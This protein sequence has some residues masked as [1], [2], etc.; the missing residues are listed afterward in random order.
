MRARATLAKSG[1]SRARPAS[2]SRSTRRGSG[3]RTG[4]GRGTSRTCGRLRR[5]PWGRGCA[6]GR[7]LRVVGKVTLGPGRSGSVSAWKARAL[8]WTR[9]HFSKGFQ[10][11]CLWGVPAFRH[12]GRAP[13]LPFWASDRD[14]AEGQSRLAD[15]VEA[16]HAHQEPLIR[17]PGAGVSRVR[18]ESAETRVGRAEPQSFRKTPRASMPAAGLEPA[19]PSGLRILSPLRLP[20]R[21][22]GAAAGCRGGACAV[23]TR[24][25]QGQGAAL[26]PPGA[27][28]LPAP[29]KGCH[30]PR[31]SSLLRAERQ[32]SSFSEE[33]EA[34]RPCTWDSEPAAGSAAQRAKVLWFFLSRKNMLSSCHAAG[35]R[36]LQVHDTLQSC[37]ITREISP[38]HPSGRRAASPTVT[39]AVIPAA[40]STL[41]GTVS[42]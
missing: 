7:D 27:G 39:V 13:G 38:C 40:S 33:K 23:Q 36:E 32:V 42:M 15:R 19:C 41:S 34:K 30:E 24:R 5:W 20:F 31:S 1:R 29:P 35:N 18:G 21:Q 3:R 12:G 14:T 10:G 8:P 37:V 4:R 25:K 28:A 17:V 11:P 6:S 2:R 16:S 9:P 22:A 26:N